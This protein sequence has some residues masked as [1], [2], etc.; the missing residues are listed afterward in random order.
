MRPVP[1]QRRPGLAHVN[2]WVPRELRD[3]FA[4][5]AADVGETVT[6]AIEWGMEKYVKD[7]RAGGK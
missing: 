6:A 3:R 2:A 1:N 4:S 7:K 5:A